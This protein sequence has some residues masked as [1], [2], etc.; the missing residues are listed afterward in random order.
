MTIKPISVKEQ[1][2]KKKK[3][4]EFP[5]LAGCWSKARAFS[6]GTHWPRVHHSR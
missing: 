6:V 2:R 4:K 5:Q 1:R 3:R